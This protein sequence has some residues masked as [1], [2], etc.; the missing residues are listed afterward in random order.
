MTEPASAAQ[1]EA[2][3]ADLWSSSIFSWSTSQTSVLNDFRQMLR[4]YDCRLAKYLA[5]VRADSP[6]GGFRR[7]DVNQLEKLIIKGYGQSK[8]LPSLRIL[9]NIIVHLNRVYQK[10]IPRPQLLKSLEQANVFLETSATAQSAVHQWL[11]ADSRWAAHILSGK[12]AAHTANGNSI[13]PTWEMVIASA[14]LH[15]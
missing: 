8:C 7:H 11:L 5:D 15:C 1:T 12:S 2:V 3:N 13:T 14:A 4:S 10:S 6:G 9:D